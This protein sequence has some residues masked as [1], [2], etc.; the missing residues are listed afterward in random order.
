[1][2]AGTVRRNGDPDS[3]EL[4]VYD[5]RL[6]A[7][8]VTMTP[9]TE[10]NAHRQ[11]PLRHVTRTLQTTH[12]GYSRHG[13]DECLRLVL[14]L[15]TITRLDDTARLPTTSDYPVNLELRLDGPYDR[16]RNVFRIRC[17]RLL[18]LY[19]NAIILETAS[20]FVS[21]DYVCSP[22]TFT[23][24]SSSTRVSGPRPH[25]LYQRS[26]DCYD[27]YESLRVPAV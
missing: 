24:R 21:P 17:I 6:T 14:R 3:H 22:F 10:D 4:H 26:H 11:R 8:T 23:V 19:V 1:M 27:C 9:R 7:D 18:S 2:G 15:T 20:S 12:D 25:S 5:T 16:L 13:I